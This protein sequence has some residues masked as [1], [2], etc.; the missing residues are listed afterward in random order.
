MDRKGAITFKGNAMTLVGVELKPGSK[1]PE[2]GVVDA[3]LKEVTLKD[4]SG[5][6]KVISVTPSLDT[7]V[8]DAQA[9]RF[10]EEAKAFPESV[11]VINMSMDLPF[12]QKRFCSSAGID[13]VTTLSDHREASFGKAYGVLIRE[14]RLLARAVFIIDK[15][16][17]VRYAEVVKEAT[18]HPDYAR[19]VSEVKKLL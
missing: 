4:F 1:A 7:P 16:D 12:A 9:R 15:D 18:D 8:C 6:V 13:R 11:A 10:N 3:A 17:I 14:F 19:A 5:K 2:F